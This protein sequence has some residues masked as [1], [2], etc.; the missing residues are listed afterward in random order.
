VGL[1]RAGEELASKVR[2]LPALVVS[3]MIPAASDLDARDEQVR[4]AEL[5]LRSTKYIAVI[6]VPLTLFAMATAEPI[7]R[8]LFAG[9]P[10]LT[11][12]A[13]IAR[14]LLVG[15]LANLLPGPGMSIA[16]GKGRAEMAMYAGTISTGCNLVLTVLF[17]MAARAGGLGQTPMLYLIATATTLAMFISTAWFFLALRRH[18]TVPLGHLA[19]VSLLWPA[20]A[21]VPG[22]A[23]GVAVSWWIAGNEG[24][25]ENF[26]A[27]AA[28]AAVFGLSYGL[29]LRTVPYLDA[30]DV[31][32]LEQTL[33]LGR[34][35]GFRRL[36]GRARH[37]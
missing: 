33:R 20:L 3:A 22:A 19:R 6:A 16:L 8:V 9:Q 1:Y 14:I 13:W 12:A 26:A 37:A 5:Y 34:I 31:E 35:P 30:F 18:V 32:F 2:Q 29:A 7:A 28:A 23:A 17:V 36:L 10:G 25:L 21:S 4:L 24:R 27:V 15:Y 11:G